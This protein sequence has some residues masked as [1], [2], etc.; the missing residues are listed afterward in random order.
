MPLPIPEFIDKFDKRMMSKVK[1]PEG[2]LRYIALGITAFGSAPVTV[3][4]E[5][6]GW[7]F[8]PTLVQVWFGLALIADVPGHLMF[9]VPSR[10]IFQRQR[11]TPFTKAPLIFDKWNI[12]SFP[13][14]HSLRTWTLATIGCFGV[15]AFSYLFIII[16]A[17]I[18]GTRI[19]L[20]RHYP[21]DIIVG[22]LLGVVLGILMVTV[23]PAGI[24]NPFL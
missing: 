14:A 12:F 15:P 18:T 24:G 1:N 16:A 7:F 13:S 9:I 5:L 22:S 17:V 19:F 11:P 3:P 10:Y 6:A 21:S 4:L 2:I 23:F 20:R 8:A